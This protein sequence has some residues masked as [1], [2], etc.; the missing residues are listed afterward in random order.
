MKTT[1]TKTQ[2]ALLYTTTTTKTSNT[3]KKTKMTREKF[4][5]KESFFLNDDILSEYRSP[6]IIISI[7]TKNPLLFVY[8]SSKDEM[9]KKY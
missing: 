4:N 9:K 8:V 2:N 6:V 1:T 7:A 3:R 5:I